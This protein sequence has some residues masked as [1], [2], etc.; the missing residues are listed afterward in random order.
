MEWSIT[1]VN[2]GYSVADRF[3]LLPDDAQFVFDFNQPQMGAGRGGELVAANR[4]A[5][6]ALVGT[7]SGMA[8]GRL[9]RKSILNEL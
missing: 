3:D 8:V 1:I 4:K 9:G 7:G 6:P 5:F 2:L